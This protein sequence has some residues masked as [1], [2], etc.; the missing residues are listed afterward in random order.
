MVPH[1]LS[2]VINAPAA[3]RF[4]ADAQPER[5]LEAAAALGADVSGAA[6]EDAGEIL[7]ERLETMMRQTNLPS[8]LEQIGYR[9]NDVPALVEGAYAQQRLL[10]MAPKEVTKDDLADLFRAAMRYW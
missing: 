8:G 4:T 7:A 1:G 6:P 2:V 3:F 10:V 9:D 5:H